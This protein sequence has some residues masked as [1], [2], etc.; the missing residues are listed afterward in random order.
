MTVTLASGLVAT[1]AYHRADNI[2]IT[3]KDTMQFQVLT[4]VDASN[5]PAFFV[6]TFTAPYVI[7]GNNPYSQAYEYLKTKEKYSLAVDC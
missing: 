6:D 2:E 7:N 1:G 5:L 4:H 3:K